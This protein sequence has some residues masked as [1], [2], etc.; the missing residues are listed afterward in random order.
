MSTPARRCVCHNC[1]KRYLYT[2]SNPE[3]HGKWL[4]ADCKKLKHITWNC[5]CGASF[6]TRTLYLNHRRE[7][8][9]KGTPCIS[10]VA[11]GECPFCGKRIG[12]SHNIYTLSESW[13]NHKCK[14]V[15]KIEAVGGSLRF[16]MET[17]QRLK[18]RNNINN[19]TI[20]VDLDKIMQFSWIKSIFEKYH[21]LNDVILTDT[22]AQIN[23][24]VLSFDLKVLFIFDNNIS[25]KLKVMFQEMNWT[26]IELEWLKCMQNSEDVEKEIM[27]K[28]NENKN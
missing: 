18:K 5:P 12:T 2:P 6:R 27:E 28:I 20:N 9:G 16:A 7:M 4:C 26:I 15:D 1:G 13:M 22:S 14:G 25:E 24:I 17:M 8:V 23:Q 19:K 3:G 11:T 21:I 10:R